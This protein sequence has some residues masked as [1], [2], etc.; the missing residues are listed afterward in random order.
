MG[1]N[2][3][4]LM[5][6]TLVPRK[7][8]IGV[9]GTTLFCFTLYMEDTGSTKQFY[10][11]SLLRTSLFL[12]ASIFGCEAYKVYSDVETWLSPNKVFTT[13]V[14]D[15]GNFHFDKR[16]KTGTWINSN[17]FIA[18]WKMIAAEGTWAQKDWTIKVDVDAV[19]LPVRLRNY[20][21]QV[22]VTDNGIYLDNCK[23][24]SFG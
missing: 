4:C 5:P 22:E 17:M 14:E 21:G 19:F 9:P 2:G 15:P 13:K 16:K 10:D 1:V 7:Q 11:L 20:L 12:G 23:Y 24:V 8:A 3:T 18:T 6:A